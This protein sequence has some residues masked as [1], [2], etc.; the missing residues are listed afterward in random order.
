ME[1]RKNKRYVTWYNLMKGVCDYCSDI[2]LIR[3]YQ[4]KKSM[5]FSEGNKYLCRKCKNKLN[6][7]IE[8][9]RI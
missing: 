8:K 9:V 1:F 6:Y 4:L 2:K 5:G 3:S 7:G